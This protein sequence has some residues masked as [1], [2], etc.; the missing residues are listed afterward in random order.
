MIFLLEIICSPDKHY[1]GFGTIE[2]SYTR[3]SLEQISIHYLKSEQYIDNIVNNFIDENLEYFNG[4]YST[5]TKRFIQKLDTYIVNDNIVS[6]KVS[7]YI[8]YYNESNRMNCYSVAK[9]FNFNKADKKEISLDTL[10]DNRYKQEQ[11]DYDDSFVLTKNKV[12]FIKNSDKGFYEKEVKYKK[13]KDY[14]A[15]YM[16]TKENYRISEKEYRKIFSE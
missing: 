12:I 4:I 5:S 14:N 9:G 16:L 8:F 13:L 2:E 10:F 3:T 7:I 1:I 15:S 6:V 11:E